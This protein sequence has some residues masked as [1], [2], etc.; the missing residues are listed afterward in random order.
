[1]A[2]LSSKLE[3]GAGIKVYQ[4]LKPSYQCP[5]PIY[6]LIWFNL[7][8]KSSG[9]REPTGFGREGRRRREKKKKEGK[10]G[11]AGGC[12]GYPVMRRRLDDA[13]SKGGCVGYRGEEERKEKRKKE[14]KKT[15]RE[16][17]GLNP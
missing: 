8:K 12:V 9:F 3:S 7:I 13:T 6:Y 11:A 16:A 2:G 14:G 5:K 1:M 10:E 17:S 15:K 4:S